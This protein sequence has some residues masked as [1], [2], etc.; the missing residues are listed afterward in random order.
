MTVTLGICLTFILH[1]INSLS[2]V[3]LEVNVKNLKMFEGFVINIAENVTNV[4]FIFN[5]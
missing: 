2:K 3:Y 5:M 4:M 1:E